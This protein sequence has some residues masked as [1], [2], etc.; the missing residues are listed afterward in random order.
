MST[1]ETQFS[2]ILALLLEAEIEFILVGGLAAMAH[3]SA[4]ATLDVDVV[5]SRK[6]ENIAKLV[7]ALEPVS[8]YLRGAAPGLPFEF[9]EKTVR[10]GLNF[11][12]TTKLGDVDFLGEI[13]GG[14]TFET[15]VAQTD[16]RMLFDVSLLCVTLE[17]LIQLKQAAGR[18]KDLNAIAELQALLEERNKL[19]E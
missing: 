16:R 7:K 4:A 15:L 6:P 10:M 13:A 14:G 9:D 5:Y 2:N 17:K 8:P 3:G 12:L 18:P 19:S 1:P 11:T